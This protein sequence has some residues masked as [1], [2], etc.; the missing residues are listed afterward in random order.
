MMIEK[1]SDN[2]GEFQMM[3]KVLR[4]FLVF[5][6][7]MMV[8]GCDDQLR[9]FEFSFHEN[10]GSTVEGYWVLRS[11]WNGDLPVSTRAGYAF[12]GWYLNPELTT[13]ANKETV[14]TYSNHLYA[15]WLPAQIEVSVEYWL[16]DF[17]GVYLLDSTEMI[18]AIMGQSVQANPRIITGFSE[19]RDHPNRVLS[20]MP[21]PDGSMVLRLFYHRESF[22][23]TY[24]LGQGLPN[25]TQTYQYGATIDVLT[26]LEHPSFLF[27]GWYHDYTTSTEPMQFTTMPGVH[28]YL[29]A[30]WRAKTVTVTF[31]T[32]DGSPIGP[33]SGPAFAGM[34]VPFTNRPGYHLFGW[35][36]D[37]EF[38]TRYTNM[39][40]FPGEN[41]TLYAKWIGDDV[42][43]TINHW[44]EDFSGNFAIQQTMYEEGV[45]GQLKTA[46]PLVLTR[47]TLTNQH[48]NQVLSGIPLVDH[49]LTLNLYYEL[50]S[51]PIHFVSNC[52]IDLPDIAVKHGLLI[53]D[54]VGYP[55]CEGYTRGNWYLDPE[56]RTIAP[57]VMPE[58]ELTFYMRWYPNSYSVHF[59]TNGGAAITSVLVEY[60]TSYNLPDANAIGY[61]FAGWYLDEDLSIP[62]ASVE[63]MPAHSVTV[64]AKWTPSPITISF[65]TNGG[66][67]VEPI[68]V[69]YLSSYALPT[70]E[71]ADHIFGGW[72]WN[73]ALTSIYVNSGS[74]TTPVDH[75]LY[76]R[77]YGMTYYVHFD[78][79]GGDYIQGLQLASGSTITLPVPTRDGFEFLGWFDASLTT[80][81]TGT[82]MP[83]ENLQLYAKW[84][85]L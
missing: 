39:T 45:I 80:Q 15:K 73:A 33:V 59:V 17:E 36:L 51:Y 58:S 1:M 78:T 66:Q 82:T 57:Q 53:R 72:Y 38:T 79:M 81:F 31:V 26:G 35:Y 24:V 60:K 29:Y 34:Q 4:F 12:G 28:F 56:F 46:T 25:Q 69:P 77:W 16:E 23:I 18:G 6:M 76:A 84:R 37:P 10:G 42:L 68:V 65:V 61:D 40:I 43:V 47:W 55:T 13:P 41:L 71:Y 22:H 8:T 32:Y 27:Q 74:M 54:Y 62:I 21:A 63:S 83:E 20:G 48:A 9:K 7:I 2:Q 14:T 70:P 30:K 85:P 44:F 64:Y 67:A 19:N 11:T 49:P 50:R 3:R 75:T 52:N 5:M